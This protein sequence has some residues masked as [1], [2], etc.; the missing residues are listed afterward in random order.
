MQTYSTVDHSSKV[1]RRFFAL[2][3]VLLLVIAGLLG[4]YFTL[5]AATS[6]RNK[7]LVIQ[8]RI[9]NNSYVPLSDGSTVFLKVSIYTSA[10]GADTNGDGTGTATCQWATGTNAT[11]SVNCRNAAGTEPGSS[12]GVSATVTRGVF[13][14]ALGDTT[15]TNMPALP[16]DF[17]AASFYAGITVCTAAQ[18]GCDAE[19]T[20]RIRL[21]AAAYAYNADEL[22]G[23]NS[24]AFLRFHNTATGD[25][26]SSGTATSTIWRA[27]A[28]SAQA[29]SENIDLD[30]DFSTN[31]FTFTGSA[32]GTINNQRT[33]LVR[34]RTYLA[35]TGAFTL[36][37]ASTL[38]VGGPPASSGGNLFISR[39]NTLE[40]YGPTVGSFLF[41]N[42][43]SATTLGGQIFASDLDLNTNV[44]FPTDTSVSLD[45]YRVNLPSVT[46]S[47]ALT[48]TLIGL[49][50]RNGGANT[51]ITQTNGTAQINWTG[52]SV[53]KPAL[54]QTTGTNTSTGISISSGAITSGTSY[55][56]IAD[57]ASGN[58]GFGDTTPNYVLELS[59]STGIANA[60]S[61]SADDVTHGLTALHN[62]TFQQ[63]LETGTF[64]QVGVLNGG[65][66]GTGGAL[67]TGASDS[68]STG[69]RILG[70][71]GSNDPTDTVTP[72]YLSGAKSDGTTGRTD[73][74]NAETVLL[75][76]NNDTVR[77]TLLGNG[78]FGIGNDPS[79]DYLLEVG[80]LP[81]GNDSTFALSDLDVA[82]GL[83][84]IAQTDIW[85]HLGPISS[86]A[87]GGRLTMITDADGQAMELQG[88]IGSTDPTDTTPAVKIIGTISNGTTGIAD[89]AAAETVLQ[90][91]NNDNAA[92][93]TLLGS[94]NFGI[95]DATPASLFTVGS[96]DLL[97]INSN[98]S[99]TLA[100][101]A[102]SGG[103]TALS[104]TPGNHTAV[105]GQLEDFEILA[106]TNTI[107]SAVTTQPFSAF[108]QA[109]ITAATAQTVTTA[110]TMTING[111][112]LVG[113]SAAITTSIGLRI[114]AGVD[115]ITSAGITSAYGLYVDMPNGLATNRYAAAFAS[116]NVGIGTATPDTTLD[117]SGTL[118]YTPSATQDITAATGAILANAGVVIITNTTGLAVNLNTGGGATIANGATGQ[119]I[120]I[121]GAT[122]MANVTV[123]DQDSQA[124][125]NL[126][127]GAASRTISALDVLQLVFD[128]TDWLEIS[129]IAN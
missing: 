84:T 49:H 122:G 2:H 23:L 54:T 73:V 82:H 60:F 4:G 99:I 46:N 124:S 9:T 85:A 42:Y 29:N 69:M 36:I 38:T 61:M 74:G 51:Q 126:Q 100:Q 27:G 28:Y 92:S 13:T 112:P 70:V 33:M 109:T 20:P 31:T 88:V 79:P 116:G 26:V 3:F 14:L 78:N 12:A 107:T 22:D 117:V 104:I 67:L 96:G 53:E 111:P 87:G 65:G 1:G 40:L 19:M 43:P 72:L 10:T 39:A 30:V 37:N 15:V 52:L 94:G 32:G 75:V 44:T 76:S 102:V 68:D 93:L 7:P 114:H 8:G 113:G 90:V 58:V 55:A 118:S 62:G 83:T 129:F 128:G 66:A 63:Q 35:G 97:Q 50:V 21:G 115:G 108:G 16:L 110:S 71:V 5:N 56:L 25:T 57:S 59:R 6:N 119:V 81:T 121:V 45:G 101:S 48:H 47:N 11:G 123:N 64:F 18:S 89:M 34:P 86:T 127:L 41:M 17:N 103:Q 24:T 80:G 105:T 98:G 125:S 91:A 95:G 120:Y 77:L 106:H